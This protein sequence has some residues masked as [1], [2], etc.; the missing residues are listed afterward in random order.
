M[1]DSRSE[2]VFSGRVGMLEKLEYKGFASIPMLDAESDSI[3]GT[4][5]GI[6]GFAGYESDSPEGIEQA[7]RDAVDDYIDGCEVAGVYPGPKTPAAP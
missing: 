2:G 5:D 6:D 1:T 4:V 3:H 7:F